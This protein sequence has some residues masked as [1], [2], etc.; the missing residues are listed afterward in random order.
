MVESIEKYPSVLI[1][2]P[3]YEGKEYCRKE[4][5]E[6]VRR[7]SYPN[8]SFV[9]VD[10]SKKT[11]YLAKLRREGVPAVRVSRGRNSRDALANAS[12]YLRKRVLEGGH[13]YLLML[14]SDIFPKPDIIE[15]LLRHMTP[16]SPV[17][18]NGVRVVGAPY[19]IEGY[20]IRKLCV[21]VAVKNGFEVS[22]RLL[23]PEEERQFVDGS[24]KR[25]HGMGVGCVLIHRSILE[26]FPFWWSE[27]DE[28]RKR[29]GMQIKHPDVYFYMD[30]QNNYVPVYCD[31]SQYAV[32]KPSDWRMVA[33]A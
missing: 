4:F 20:G 32:H 15:K 9:M 5:V 29:G 27:L 19:H 18:Q 6:N 14:E 12:N 10:N 8:K 33:D 25:V 1:G 24:V 3:T 23:T 22:T 11:S 13:E 7:L 21:F 16:E 17:L 30:L 2:S 28:D 26:R 31:T